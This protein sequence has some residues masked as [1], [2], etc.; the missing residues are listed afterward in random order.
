MLHVN[1]GPNPLHALDFRHPATGWSFYGPAS[2]LGSY[3]TAAYRG[4]KPVPPNSIFIYSWRDDNGAQYTE[5]VDLRKRV[6]RHFRG[7]MVFIVDSE[8]RLTVEIYKREG[9]FRRPQRPA[10]N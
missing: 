1:T 10:T 4:G 7:E 6:S 5:E 3:S 9:D 2:I 8:N